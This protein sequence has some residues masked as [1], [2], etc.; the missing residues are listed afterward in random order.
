MKRGNLTK[1]TAAALAFT[2]VLESGYA[3]TDLFTETASAAEKVNAKLV[4]TTNST[5]SAAVTVK[6][7][8]N[9]RKLSADSE[10]E[11]KDPNITTSQSVTV[12]ASYQWYKDDKEILN[13]TGKT[14][15][16]PA[17]QE[18]MFGVKV[19]VNYNG[20]FYTGTSSKKEMHKSEGIIPEFEPIT[21]NYGLTRQEILDKVKNLRKDVTFKNSSINANITWKNDFVYDTTNINEQKL[22]LEG[23]VKVPDG[24]TNAGKNIPVI[25]TVVISAK[26]AVKLGRVTIDGTERVGKTLKAVVKD[27]DGNKVTSGLT[28]KWYRLKKKDSAEDTWKLVETDSEYK[29]VS[30]DEDKYIKLIV[31][32]SQGNVEDMTGRIDERSSSSSSHHH[33]YDDDDDVKEVTG[34]TVSSD[35]NE[36]NGQENS[37]T[38]RF[39]S[40]GN[41]KLTNS[42]GQPVSG[43]RQ[44]NGNWYL[45]DTLGNVLTGWQ[46]SNGSWYFMDVDGVMK[47][48][49]QNLNGS[50]YYFNPVSDGT[51][52]SMKTGW[53]YID[54]AWYYM[55]DNGIMASNTYIGNYYVG[56]NGAWNWK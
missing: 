30:S 32:N 7:N 52:G 4:E 26:N 47:T 22:T 31:S 54:N 10:I 2:A 27:T 37:A 33:Y 41:R 45:G 38:V 49:W 43:W 39:D 18:G 11:I 34:T 48:G 24:F 29:L 15:T 14:Y 3:S 19:T 20:K 13:A 28:Y 1:T 46:I 53:Q 40:N 25:Q 42:N 51:R 50:W 5:T 56:S 23:T 9:D 6:I 12:N 36:Y 55:Y 44:I 16:V 8:V 17:D 35:S 21:V